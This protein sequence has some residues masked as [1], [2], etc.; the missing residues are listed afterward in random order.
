MR[1][2]LHLSSIMLNFMKTLSNTTQFGELKAE[3][4]MQ[5]QI[6]VKAFYVG[7]LLG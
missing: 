1:L 7:S 2:L 5:T 4:T 6:Y 3:P